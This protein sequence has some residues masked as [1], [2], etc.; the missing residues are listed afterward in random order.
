MAEIVLWENMGVESRDSPAN[1]PFVRWTALICFLATGSL[2]YVFHVFGEYAISLLCELC[3]TI[4]I[5][6]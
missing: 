4:S 6:V 2:T 5:G 3:L 1:W